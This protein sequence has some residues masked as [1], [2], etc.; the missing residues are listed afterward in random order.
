MCDVL[1]GDWGQEPAEVCGQTA[2]GSA[3]A[4]SGAHHR[5]EDAAGAVSDTA[6]AASAILVLSLKQACPNAALK[7]P[8]ELVLMD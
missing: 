7:R 1:E 2:R 4:A 8:Y 6:T 5:E 3:A